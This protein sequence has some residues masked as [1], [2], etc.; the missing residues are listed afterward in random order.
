VLPVGRSLRG[1]PPGETERRAPQVDVDQ[2]V[3]E[4]EVVVLVVVMGVVVSLFAGEEG[5]GW[6]GGG[7]GGEQ[8]GRKRGVEL[9]EGD[10]FGGGR[11]LP[12]HGLGVHFDGLELGEM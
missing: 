2:H 12:L 4:G 5:R 8:E 6:D 10:D 3:G 1:I 7:G 11:V 9:D